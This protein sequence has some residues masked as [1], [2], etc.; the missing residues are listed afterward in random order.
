MTDEF[1]DPDY[2]EDPDGK[3]IKLD[4]HIRL[5]NPRTTETEQNLIL[6]RGFNYSR[7][8]DGAGGST[9]GWRSSPT[10]AA[11]RRAF[12]PCRAG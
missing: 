10:S 1:A 8:F 4:A 3:R 9:R 2:A 11:C 6:R 7:G 12:S 5:A